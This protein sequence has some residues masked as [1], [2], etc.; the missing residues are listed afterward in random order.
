MAAQIAG[1]VTGAA[2]VLL[3]WRGWAVSVDVGATT[4]RVGGPWAAAAAETAMTFL[5][6]RLILNFVDRPRLMQF[7]ALGAKESDAARR[8][9]DRGMPGRFGRRDG[10]I[11][12]GRQSS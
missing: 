7:A 5:L 10:G 8:A 12:R 2:L 4:P 3:I 11:A 9:A 6:V 1:A